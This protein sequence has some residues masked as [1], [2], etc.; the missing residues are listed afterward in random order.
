[1]AI[2]TP[3]WQ[4]LS[5]IFLLAS[6]VL[7]II[8][9]LLFVFHANSYLLAPVWNM[10][11]VVSCTSLYVLPADPQY[12]YITKLLV[13]IYFIILM[14]CSQLTPQSILHPF[15]YYSLLHLELN[16]DLF[17]CL[18]FVSVI[19]PSSCVLLAWQT[20]VSMVK[21]TRRSLQ[22]TC[23][24]GNTTPDALHF[25]SQLDSDCLTAVP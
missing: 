2:F 9:I 24:L 25:R 8:L 22:P 18:V 11:I 20:L 5:N 17:L 12:R 7:N 1:L 15:S 16:I 13:N 21:P 3:R 23:F 10:R 6:I 4:F 19:N 14:Y